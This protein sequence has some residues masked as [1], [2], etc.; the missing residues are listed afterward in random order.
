MKK[1]LFVAPLMVISLIGCNKGGGDK[2]E[3]DTFTV[4]FNAN[5]GTLDS[6]A[7]SSIDV[8]DGTLF[9]EIPNITKQTATK[10]IDY[11]NFSGWGLT[12]D[13]QIPINDYKITSDLTVYA[14]YT[15]KATATVYFSAFSQSCKLSY[16]GAKY[17]PNSSFLIPAGVEVTLTI[18]SNQ[19]YFPI[20]DGDVE[21]REAQS[22]SFNLIEKEIII[23]VAQDNVC[24]IKAVAENTP[25]E[26]L[27][28]YEWSEINILSKAGL[29]DTCFD[30]GDTKEVTL[31][32]QDFPHTVRIIGFNHD[33]L[34]DGSGKAGITFEFADV[35]TKDSKEEAYTTKWDTPNNS[36]YRKSILNNFLNNETEG[37][38]SVI[39]MLPD[40]LSEEGII[41]SVNKLV[42][43]SETQTRGKFTATSFET[44]LFSLAYHEIHNPDSR[45]V[46]PN[47]TNGIYEYYEGHG[48]DTDEDNIYRV[49]K[50]V[51][52]G[53]GVSFWLRSP[54]MNFLTDAF[55]VLTGGA[56]GYGQVTTRECAVAPAFC[57]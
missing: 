10:D 31:K 7:S 8:K 29:A 47:E 46:T 50:I 3:P 25:R 37:T 36:D 55:R 16:K 44:K 35:I 49:K 5:G 51:D 15:P 20:L 54:A 30:V 26:S 6:G 57:I 22:Y 33:D 24:V 42:G 43:V 2:P 12:K 48:G 27:E 40:D 21:I 28:S 39:N 45:P 34:A 41:K 9:S 53:D 52:G 23:K 11:F 56:L 18:K 32:G 4:T 38:T 14:I 13:T 17:Q 1:I 19:G